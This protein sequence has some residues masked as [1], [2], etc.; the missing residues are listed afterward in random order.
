MDSHELTEILIAAKSYL[1][2]LNQ[3]DEELRNAINQ[4]NTTYEHTIKDIINT[5]SNLKENL[6]RV[7]CE[8]EKCLQNQAQMVR[9]YLTLNYK[10]F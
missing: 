6:I 9:L 8:R 10:N 5:F 4:I 3:L 7:L 1:V 2:R